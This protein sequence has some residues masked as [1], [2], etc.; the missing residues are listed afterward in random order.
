ME[1]VE[2]TPLFSIPKQKTGQK[3]IDTFLRNSYRTHIAYSS[4][5]DK[6]AN[7]MIKFNSIVISILIVF[8]ESITDL[9]PAAYFSGII[10]LCSALVSL[11][12]ATLSASPE[13]TKVNTSKGDLDIRK[14]NLLFFGNYVD[15]EIEEYEIAFDA[16][17]QD[18]KLVYGNMAR[19]LYFLGK[20]LDKKFR[21]LKWSYNTFLTGLGFTVFAFLISLYARSWIS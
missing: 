1:V 3:G 2:A 20:V 10:F 8:F 14:R 17:M 15:M 6:K 4:L 12:F 5:A 13:I 19:D 21:Y 7:I 18:Y 11:A 9:S 16:M